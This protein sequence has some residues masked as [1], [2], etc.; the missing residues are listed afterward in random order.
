MKETD[1]P[2]RIE[3]A[4]DGIENVPDGI[5]NV[6]D[7]IENVPDRIETPLRVGDVPI[8]AQLKLRSRGR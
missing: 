2:D 1:A 8:L 6:P 5:E 4:P 7:R 3:N